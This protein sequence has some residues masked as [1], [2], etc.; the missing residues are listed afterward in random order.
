MLLYHIYEKSP[1]KCCEL[2]GIVIELKACLESTEMPSKGEIRPLR[3]CRTHFLVHKVA[4]LD[5]IMDRFHLIA[6]T[7]DSSVKPADKAKMKAY[8]KNWQTP[9]SCLVVPSCMTC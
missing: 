4:A 8:V 2:E 7:E 5:R 1:K 9:R 3:A 6:M